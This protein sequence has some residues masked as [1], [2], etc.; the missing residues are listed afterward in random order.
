MFKLGITGG[1]ACGKTT[2]TDLLSQKGLP[3]VD[4][5]VGV[6]K[7]YKQE[8][9]AQAIEAA[10]G[11][12]DKHKIRDI[13]FKD[14]AKKETLEAILHPP[15]MK[16]MDDQADQHVKEGHKVVGFAIPLLFEIEVQ[17]QFDAILA[18]VCDES[19]QINRLQNRDKLTLAQAREVIA[20]QWSMDT[21]ANKADYVIQN[22]Q[23]LDQLEEEVDHFYHWL[24][25]KY[26]ELS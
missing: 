25:H 23:G 20:N 24:V 13:V 18:V 4:A 3:I 26:P 7:L 6:A 14:P 17:D 19:N 16:W 2:V 8:S 10:L 21:K 22:N 9:I 5:D 11:T 12:V 15:V 1:I